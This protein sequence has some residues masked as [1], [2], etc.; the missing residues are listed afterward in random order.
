MTELLPRRYG[1]MAASP[2]AFFRGASAI[3][4]ADL[5][6]TPTTGLTVQACGDCHLLNFG[7]YSTPERSRVFDINDFD[8]TLP[9]PWEWDLKR[10][11]TSFVLAA[12]E[13]ECRAEEARDAAM[14]CSQ[15]YREAM[16][17]FA[18][19]AA[20]EVWYAR[21]GWDSL[22]R[23]IE[24]QADRKP[25]RKKLQ[26]N[27]AKQL[28]YEYPT[29]VEGEAD[30]PRIEDRP[31]RMVHPAN[32]A[33]RAFAALV[34]D[35]F[36]NYRLSLPEDRQRLLDRYRVADIVLK[37]V[38]VGSVGT[39]CGVAL[40]V[41]GEGDYL[42]LQIKEARPSV[43][44]PFAGAAVHANRG[45]RIVLGQRLIQS[46]SDLFLGWTE[47]R[48]GRH[49]TVRQL[50]DLKLKPPVE[51]FASGRLLNSY[52]HAC[53]WT[54]ARAHARSGDAARISGYLGKSEVFDEALTSFALGYAEQT[55]RDHEA[56]TTAIL[57]GRVKAETV[58]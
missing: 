8:E 44:E 42:F 58:E 35:A 15:A 18:Q 9:A 4:A 1:L 30:R 33:S 48:D 53:G 45:Q 25:I 55:E 11:A 56:L 2:F 3:M 14:T 22:A 27:L 16:A 40:L 31:P 26:Q 38:G 10:L 12:R 29:V 23:V 34:D 20:L 50:R 39:W 49:F 51:L 47:T 46:A 52:A 36:V 37:V 5:A 54:L 17:G 43:L 41:A 32:G 19:M 6:T 57:A 24:E 7:G 21:L 13:N 28:A